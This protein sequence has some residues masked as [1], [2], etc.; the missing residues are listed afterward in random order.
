MQENLNW[1]FGTSWKMQGAN[2]LRGCG[3]DSSFGLPTLAFC[4]NY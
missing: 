4:G 3:Q 2:R 1:E